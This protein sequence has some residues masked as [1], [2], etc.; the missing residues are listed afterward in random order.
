M[1]N[2]TE[3]TPDEPLVLLMGVDTE[4]VRSALKTSGQQYKMKRL[5]SSPENWHSIIE[6][7]THYA[8]AA[9]VVKLTGAVYRLLADPRYQHV[10]ETLFDQLASVPHAIFI[11]EDFL[12]GRAY[13][14]ASARGLPTD[15]PG[16]TTFDTFYPP[17]PELAAFVTKLLHDKRL[18]VVPYTLNAQMTV[19][20][21]ALIA[22]ATNGL[23]FRV[24]VPSGRLWA[25][26][27][28]KI[29]QLFRD[30]LTRIG[31]TEIRF[32]QRRTQNGVEYEFYSNKA[33]GT[34][35]PLSPALLSQQFEQF[36]EVLELCV[37]DPSAAEALL[38]ERN[39]DHREIAG[40]LSRYSKEA[41]RLQL[42]MKQERE[43]KVLAIRHRLES[44]LTDAAPRG[45]DWALIDRI[46][47]TAVPVPGDI[48]KALRGG[49]GAVEFAPSVQGDLTINIGTNVT[50]A[51]NSIVAQ[52]I[53][54][55]ATLTPWDVDLIKLVKVH[56]NERI[57]EL[58][59]AVRQLQ[60]KT[61]PAPTR[62]AAGQKLKAFLYQLG[63][64]GSDLAVK[65][66]IA[67]IE[68]QLGL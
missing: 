34:R 32:D 30:Y 44:E 31:H 62:L 37:S 59:S 4:G 29:L 19:L 68:K 55:N 40:I 25:N 48:G 65:A 41:R 49:I 15:D 23:L 63:S 53:S 20:A 52:E 54:G 9:A 5:D 60:D 57:A 39:V 61:V 64:K 1:S 22:D 24:Y 28:D 8:V 56:A 7:F 43:Q 47:N 51:V 10:R 50:E 14:E 2:P 66:L 13:D 11:Y 42:D 3:L 27:L 67:Y 17:D 35:P 21:S 36:T 12:N 16:A 26:E 6:Y 46:V 38:K 18:N 33:D 45:L 58:E